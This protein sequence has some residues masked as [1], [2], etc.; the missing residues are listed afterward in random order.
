MLV[1]PTASVPI[2]QLMVCPVLVQPSGKDPATGLSVA[3]S[4]TVTT[5]PREVEGPALL[6]TIWKATSSPART[7]GV[8]AANLTPRS[9]DAE[10]VVV[11]VAVL[12]DVVGSVGPVASTVAVLD[13]LVAVRSTSTRPAI[14]TTTVAPLLS[15]PSA[16]V[17][18]WL[19]RLQL[20]PPAMLELR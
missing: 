8:V 20:P 2:V 11:E 19:V 18:S 16:H 13:V 9:A 10:T 15:E 3:G 1:S 17:R 12:L 6:T 14:V 7:V 4:G 5:V